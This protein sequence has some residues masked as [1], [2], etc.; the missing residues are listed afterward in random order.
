MRGLSSYS[1][2]TVVMHML[3]K[4]YDAISWNEKNQAD[5]FLKV[6]KS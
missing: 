1:L 3:K 2:K 5:I 6:R 4:D